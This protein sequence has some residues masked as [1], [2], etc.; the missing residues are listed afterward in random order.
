MIINYFSMVRRSSNLH[1][2][3]SASVGPIHCQNNSKASNNESWERKVAYQHRPRHQTHQNDQ[4]KLIQQRGNRPKK[5]VFSKSIKIEQA[6][7]WY[8]KIPLLVATVVVGE[9]QKL[10]CSS[11]LNQPGKILM[12]LI[13][14]L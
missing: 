6:T 1:R 3:R 13:N 14:D 10:L 4:H 11:F 8:F 9:L 7:K 5:T 12:F 2:K